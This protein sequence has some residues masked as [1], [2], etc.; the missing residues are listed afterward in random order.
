MVIHS[1]AFSKSQ[2][3]PQ[4]YTCKGAGISPPLEISDIPKNTRSLALMMI[5]PDS[6][7]GTFTHWLLWNINPTIK[8]IESGIIPKG[9]VEGCNT[10]KRVGYFP[11]CP[12]DKSI[13]QYQFILY[14][15]DHKL[16]LDSDADRE[17]LETAVY[18]HVLAQAELIGQYGRE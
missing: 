16:N 15:L 7:N 10:K 12:P 1:P 9:S 2:N 13:H 17:K 14:A 5:D 4:T 8:V 11:P 18:G 3:I 6:P